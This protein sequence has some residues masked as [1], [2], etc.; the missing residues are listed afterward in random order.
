MD[1]RPD[2]AGD[3]ILKVDN[4]T[5][6]FGEFKALKDL[7]FAMAR[8]ELR[9]VI[10]PNGAGKTTLLDVITGK[11][12]PRS[13]RVWFQPAARPRIDVTRLAVQQIARL[14]V[15]RKFQTPN[16]FKD[17]TV[18]DNLLLALEFGRG[19]L[20]TLAASFRQDGRVR[21]EEI[22]HTIGLGP[23]AFRKAGTLRTGK[24]SGS[25][26]AWSWPRGLS[27]S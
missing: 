1:A 19:V 8:G 6:A 13:G 20:S 17:L 22:L 18:V 14:G 11:T 12:R 21:I 2:T 26:S 5:V 23:K 9:V 24:S 27:C 25:K 16:V 10:G 4:V 15:G 7:S 3:E